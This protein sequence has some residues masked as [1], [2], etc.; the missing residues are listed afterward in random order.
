MPSGIGTS[1]VPLGPCTFN[2]SPDCIFPTSILTPEGNGIGF[3]PTL[4]IVLSQ[5]MDMRLSAASLPHP[6]QRGWQPH[7]LPNPAQ[8]FPADAF[9]A[10]CPARHHAPRR[11]QDTDSEAALH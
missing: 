11:G 4:D 7:P 3:F 5:M 2:P 1:R 6:N 8:D 10:R 9:L